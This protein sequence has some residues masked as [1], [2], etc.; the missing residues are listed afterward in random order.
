MLA[1]S[2]RLGAMLRSWI[3]QNESESWY[4]TNLFLTRNI[5]REGKPS[6]SV[7]VVCKLC[8]ALAQLGTT[9]NAGIYTYLIIL[10]EV[11]IQIRVQVWGY[12]WHG[13]FHRVILTACRTVPLLLADLHHPC[14]F[15]SS[16]A[17]NAGTDCSKQLAKLRTFSYAHPWANSKLSHQL[18]VN[19]LFRSSSEWVPQGDDNTLMSLV[20]ILS[21]TLLI[22]HF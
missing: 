18:V 22:L 12:V 1:I 7:S 5:D 15:E 9:S 19:L 8:A 14:D 3:F 6:I 11:A 13:R 10:S 4:C 17:N 20:S 16:E 2:N 21:T